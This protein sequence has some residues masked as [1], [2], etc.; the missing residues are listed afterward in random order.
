VQIIKD[1]IVQRRN[2]RDFGETTVLGEA[3]IVLQGA[4][5][6]KK[7]PITE[8]DIVGVKHSESAA[9]QWTM[10]QQQ[11]TFTYPSTKRFTDFKTPFTGDVDYTI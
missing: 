10:L 6:L 3:N 7:E 2:F 11:V 9:S 5:D 8:N 4:F 1:Q